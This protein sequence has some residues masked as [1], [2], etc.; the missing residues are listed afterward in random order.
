MDPQHNQNNEELLEVE[1]RFTKLRSRVL[2]PTLLFCGT[3]FVFIFLVIMTKSI[4]KSLSESVSMGAVLASMLF[5]TYLV[6]FNRRN[7]KCPSCDSRWRPTEILASYNWDYC[8]QCGVQLKRNPR[9]SINKLD[10]V[11]LT[12]LQLQFS[13][14]M[15]WANRSLI[16]TIPAFFFGSFLL[17]R[18]TGLESNIA[19]ICEAILLGVVV[20]PILYFRRCIFCKAGIRGKS[21]YCFRCGTSLGRISN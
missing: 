8:A 6:L 11:D 15:R 16:I 5:G 7:W 9:H 2:K 1:K 18:K 20:V 14:N 13:R 3:F 4:S 21:S 17:L 10:T 12:R 19:L